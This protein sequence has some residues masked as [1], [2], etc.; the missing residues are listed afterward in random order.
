MYALVN[1][2]KREEVLQLRQCTT[3]I[4]HCAPL[5]LHVLLPEFVDR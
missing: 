2:C 4:V 1:T 5:E 3:G